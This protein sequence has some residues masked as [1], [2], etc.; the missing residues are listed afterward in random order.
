MTSQEKLMQLQDIGNR[1]HDNATCWDGNHELCPDYERAASDA[2][3]F[4]LRHHE[5]LAICVKAAISSP[6]TRQAI[7]DQQS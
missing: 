4:L 2:S 7:M 5:W 6:S 3:D 1:L